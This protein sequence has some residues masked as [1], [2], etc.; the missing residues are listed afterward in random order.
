MPSIE[1]RGEIIWGAAVQGLA[2]HR[3]VSGEKLFQFASVDYLG[4]YLSCIKLILSQ[5]TGFLALT[6]PIL[7][8]PPSRWRRVT[9]QLCHSQL[10][11]RVKL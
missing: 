9:E 1:T 5:P 2:G 7:L 8:F 4:F 3:W 10:P 11:A 6:L